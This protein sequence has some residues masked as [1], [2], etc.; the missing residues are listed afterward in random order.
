MRLAKR[1]IFL[2]FL[3][4]SVVIFTAVG[5]SLAKPVLSQVISKDISPEWDVLPGS[6]V[7]I[8]IRVPGATKELRDPADIMLVMDTTGSMGLCWGGGAPCP[9]RKLASAKTALTTFVNQTD[10]DRDAIGGTRGDFVGLVQYNTS[11]AGKAR[12]EFGIKNMTDGAAPF[13]PPLPEP[14]NKNTLITRINAL[15]DAGATSI[16]AGINL[17]N[18]ESLNLIEPATTSRRADGV[19]QYMVLATDGIQNMTPS[20]YEKALPADP[21]TILNTTI[22]SKIAVFTIGIGN[23]VNDGCPF[24]EATGKYA[25]GCTGGDQTCINCDDLDNDGNL[26]GAEVMKDIACR[27][28]QVDLDPSKRCQMV[29]NTTNLCSATDPASVNDLDCP[30]NYFFAP[31]DSEL[32][33]IYEK[34]SNLIQTPRWYSIIDLINPDV[35]IG[36]L[37]DFTVTDCDTGAPWPYTDM[38]LGGLVFWIHLSDPVPAGKTVC[39]NF[40]AKVRNDA[41]SGDYAVDSP[42]LRKVVSWD[43]T[44]DCDHFPPPGISI[45]DLFWCLTKIKELPSD[46]IPGGHIQVVNPAKPWLQTTG[47]D[48]GVR[49]DIDVDRDLTDPSATP[50]G[51]QQYNADYLIVLT[52]VV[53]PGSKPFTSAKNWL[54]Q[55]YPNA[56]TPSLDLP[57]FPAPPTSMYQALWDRYSRRCPTGPIPVD[58][59]TPGNVAAAVT[60]DC[61]ILQHD[62]PPPGPPPPPNDLTINNA[63]WGAVGYDSSNPPAVIFVDGDL[64]IENNIEIGI[65]T[66]LIF[67]VRGDISIAASVRQIDGIYIT[68]GEFNTRG[69]AGCG[70]GSNN[71]Q[72]VIN[73]AVYVFGTPCFN[74]DLANNLNDPAEKIIFEPKYLWLFRDIIGDPKVVYREI[75]P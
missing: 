34:I 8:T 71:D 35:F 57:P 72:L 40:K 5:I 2:I 13:V 70:L 65:G 7:E 56:A 49:G 46:E 10:E 67:V 27:T 6:E 26:S 23:D 17:A 68:D 55:S 48:V 11:L 69:V 74:R 38:G 28:D 62:E 42:L 37:T 25:K 58:V 41:P 64:T 22:N 18:K 9:P 39:I 45:Q 59:N 4:T 24:N 47:G 16:G 63:S 44:I 20:P 1:P 36:S 3:I 61:N 73:G 66:G 52:G 43:P 53:S 19:G 21:D 50:G 12:L 51:V 75:A 54:V 33:T 29:W 32:T 31:S 60:P 15:T 14:N 30:R